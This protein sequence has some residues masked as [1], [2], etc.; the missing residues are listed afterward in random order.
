MRIVLTTIATG[1]KGAK[2]A[3][4]PPVKCELKNKSFLISTR[5]H[6]L[7]AEL[8]VD[9]SSPKDTFQSVFAAPAA[10]YHSISPNV[11]FRS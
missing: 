9:P 3:E 5:S 1:G 8:D 10:L 6:S 4:A 11:T 2:G 7:T